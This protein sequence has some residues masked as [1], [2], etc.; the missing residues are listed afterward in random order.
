MSYVDIPN[1]KEVVQYVSRLLNN[2]WNLKYKNDFSPWLSDEYIIHKRGESYSPIGGVEVETCVDYYKLQEADNSIQS[3]DDINERLMKY[4]FYTATPDGSI[5]CDPNSWGIEFVADPK[6]VYDVIDAPDD[7]EY[8][9][10][11]LNKKGDISKISIGSDTKYFLTG[12][13]T[14]CI[15]SSC[16]THVH[17]SIPVMTKDK[18][19]QFNVI[20]RY[21]WIQFY[22]PIFIA[23]FDK[24]DERWKSRFSRFSTE[25]PFGKYEMFNEYPSKDDVSW[26]FEFR[27]LGSAEKDWSFFCD[28]VSI[29]LNMWTLAREFYEEMPKTNKRI[30]IYEERLENMS[31]NK[32]LQMFFI[33]RKYGDPDGFMLDSTGSGRV[34]IDTLYKKYFNDKLTQKEILIK[35]IDHFDK[36]AQEKDFGN[37]IYRNYL[38]GNVPMKLP[39]YSIRQTNQDFNPDDY[40]WGWDG[41]DFELESSPDEASDSDYYSDLDQDLKQI[42]HLKF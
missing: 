3:L 27:A 6:Y 8:V 15:L 18:Y 31:T 4:S 32:L 38:T 25:V 35:C 10:D 12:F 24:G 16:G 5:R 21:F 30:E 9:Y 22:Q 37:Y 33:R 40:D 20:M 13:H 36:D 41:D 14:D 42:P 2:K 17:M 29:L 39:H 26:H 34:A 11:Y 1:S 23:Q 7:G 19:P 28:Y